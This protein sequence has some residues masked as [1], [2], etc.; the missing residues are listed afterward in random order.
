MAVNGIVIRTSFSEQLNELSALGKLYVRRQFTGG[1]SDALDGIDGANLQNGE[2]A[3]VINGGNFY[4][5]EYI[6]GATDPENPPYVITPDTNANGRWFLRNVSDSDMVDGFHASQNPSANMIP[7]LDG[8][9]IL[10]LPFAVPPIK[11]AGQDL[12]SRTFYVDQV[13]GDDGND[14]SE[15]AP[16]KTIQKAIDSVPANGKGFIHILGDYTVELNVSVEGRFIWIRPYGCLRFSW[17]VTEVGGSEYAALHGLTLRRYGS[18]VIESS[19]TYG[20]WILVDE[21]DTGVSAIN[22]FYK[23]AIRVGE[24]AVFAGIGIFIRVSVDNFHPIVVKSGR[25]IAIYGWSLDRP[26]AIFV[27]IHGHYSGTN[28]QIQVNTDSFLL[29]CQKTPVTFYYNYEGGL[30]DLDG[31]GISIQDVV[32]SVVKDA[33]GVPRNIISNIIF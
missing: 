16:F 8:S 11:V 26:A 6:E 12:M 14:G 19:S 24:D 28:R 13:N 31:N 17:E 33:N 10:N 7:V 18:L 23:G 15:S 30:A 1:G 4:F 9:G 3:L 5:Y 2:G 21:N 22:P 20:G 27:G 25:L 32:A 29:D